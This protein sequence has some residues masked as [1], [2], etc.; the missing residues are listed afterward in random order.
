MSY[1]Q[2]RAALLVVTLTAPLAA[3]ARNESASA[4][5]THPQPESYCVIDIGRLP[6]SSASGVFVAVTPRALN[7]RNQIVGSTS[8]PRRVGRSVAFIWDRV[9][10]M[11]ALGTLPGHDSSFAEDINDAGKVVGSSGDFETGA[12][13]SFIWDKING[14]REL[15]ASLGGNTHGARGINRFGEVVGSS[16]TA[17][18]IEHAFFRDRRGDVFDLGTLSNV[19]PITFALAVNDRGTVVGSDSGGPALSHAF[20]WDERPGMRP[21]GEPADTSVTPSAINNKGEVVGLFSPPDRNRAFR[22]TAR[23]GFQDLGS[24]GGPSTDAHAINRWGVI[25][26]A[27]QKADLSGAPFIWNR[28]SGMRNLEEMVDPTSPP[29]PHARL[30]SAQGIND[31]GWIVTEGVDLRDTNST[32]TF[33]LAPRRRSDTSACQ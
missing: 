17:S 30:G 29:A 7:N 4:V 14:M 22:W 27:S 1:K 28:R 11:R 25:V 21:L 12:H 26:G 13:L 6:G 5:K 18:G 19:N 8:D 10:G 20:I 2:L 9:R 16:H 15:D 33:L 31:L 23:D 32:H 24:L 3:A